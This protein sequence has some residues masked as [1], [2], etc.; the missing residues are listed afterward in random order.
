MEAFRLTAMDYL[1]K[2]VE[3]DRLEETIGRARKLVADRIT[4]QQPIP[5]AAHPIGN[6]GFWK[7]CSRSGA[8]RAA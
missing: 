3:R 6:P 5:P 2:P 4:E 8:G 7:N 1:L